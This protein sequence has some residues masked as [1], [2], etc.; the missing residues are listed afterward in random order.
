M[1]LRRLDG[2]LVRL[3][4]HDA[5][6]G[7]ESVRL[8]DERQALRAHEIRIEIGGGEGGIAGRGNAVPLQ[9]LLGECLRSFEARGSA[10]GPEASAARRR[11]AVDDA[12]NER[13]LRGPRW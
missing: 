1:P 10:R 6:A 13:R 4:D 11:E 2:R 3:A 7:G 12:G 8:Y 5:L 9:E